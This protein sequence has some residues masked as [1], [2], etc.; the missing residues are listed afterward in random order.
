MDI[1]SQFCCTCCTFIFSP[2]HNIE[3]GDPVVSDGNGKDTIQ[4]QVI[5]QISLNQVSDISPLQPV[6]ESGDP[7]ESEVC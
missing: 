5:R 6:L 7:S 3:V 4:D 2:V 1:S